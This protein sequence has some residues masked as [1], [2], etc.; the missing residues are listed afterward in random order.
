MQGISSGGTPL[1]ILALH[2][3]E[4]NVYTKVQTSLVESPVQQPASDQAQPPAP[5]LGARNI[6]RGS[7][8][9]SGLAALTL[10][11]AA[12]GGGTSAYGAGGY[13]AP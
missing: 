4:H 8:A 10:V 3:E 1:D 7:L 12:C 2:P 13:G 5:G 11:L 6:R 9:A